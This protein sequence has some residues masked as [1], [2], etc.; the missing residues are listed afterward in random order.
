M[1]EVRVIERVIRKK[2]GGGERSKKGGVGR[3][4]L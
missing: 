1:K 2:N 4:R 3:V